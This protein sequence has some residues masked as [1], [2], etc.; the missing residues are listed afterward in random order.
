MSTVWGTVAVTRDYKITTKCPYC[1]VVNNFTFSFNPE[2]FSGTC[3]NINCKKTY[4]V[5]TI[6]D[7]DII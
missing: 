7:G 1:N 6:C 3:H 4:I 5:K 2:K